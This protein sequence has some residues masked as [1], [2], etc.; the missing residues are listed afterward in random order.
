MVCVARIRRST[1]GAP[2]RAG[3]AA[4]FCGRRGG[5][6]GGPSLRGAKRRS[7]PELCRD[8]ELLR[9]ARNDD[10]RDRKSQGGQSESVPTISNHN[11]AMV[12]TAQVRLCPPYFFL[13]GYHPSSTILPRDLPDSN[14]AW[15]RFRLAALMAPKVWSRVVRSTPLSIRSA[16]S[17]KRACWPIMS[18]VWNEERVNIDSQWI[19]IALP[20]N[21]LTVNSGGSSISPNFPCGAMKSAI[22]L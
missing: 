1:Q 3:A 21:T 13:N 14:S 18:G 4:D 16:T 9:F 11:L 20:L 2:D 5:V 17:F 19:E 22:A 7:N 6:R 15:A 10:S 8:S 12:A